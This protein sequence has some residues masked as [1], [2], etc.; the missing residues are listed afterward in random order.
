MPDGTVKLRVVRPVFRRLLD[1][2]AS[3]T[4]TGLVAYDLDRIARDPRDLEDLIDVIEGRQHVPVRTVTGGTDL[5]NDNGIMMARIMV[6]IANKSSRDTS[7][8]VERK[9]LELAEQGRVGGGGIR[10]YGYARDGLA[11]V[12]SE[13]AII[14]ELAERVIAGDSL[15][16]LAAD[17][18]A[19]KI[20]TV[21]AGTRWNAR[22]VHSVVS[23]GRNAGLR[24]HKGEVVG[25][26]V[27]PAIIDQETWQQVKGALADR[28]AGSTNTLRF[29]LTG[30]L[31]CS[32][33]GRPL[34]G[35]TIGGGTR[36][37]TRYWCATPRGGC[38]KIAVDAAGS[39]DIAGRL[40]VAYLSRPDVLADLAAAT[41]HGNAR[42]ARRDAA[43][44]ETQLAEL[45]AMWG[46]RKVTTKE[47]LAARKPIE[48]RLA[49]SKAIMR[50]S[51]PP[52]VRALLS[53]V[54]ITTAWDRLTAPHDRREVARIVFPHG[55]TVRPAKLRT[56]TFD[57]NRLVPVTE[58][59][60]RRD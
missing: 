35:S 43:D 19:R 59:D 6:G 10:S 40:I 41:S 50:A 48:G 37:R 44:D 51:T 60:A 56:F 7:R 11:I 54:D 53:S 32:L 38:G 31:I 16:T 29:W 9:H 5:S 58:K 34:I 46:A 25:P 14:R 47:Y 1:D 27:W 15:S 39:E 21:L 17:L 20:P 3:G 18:T 28:A 8:R 2:L 45:A 36:P 23:K 33:C 52:G 4:I 49:R 24:E 13:A 26:A 30:V 12:D 22:S 42:Q 55:I 57:P